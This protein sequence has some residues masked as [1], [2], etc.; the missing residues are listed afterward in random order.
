MQN[1]RS[2]CVLGMIGEDIILCFGGL[3]EYES[4]LSIDAV[5][6][7]VTD[8]SISPVFVYDGIEIGSY[9]LLLR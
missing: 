2:N 9:R 6:V 7:R 8:K 3:Y 4:I 5:N 1:P